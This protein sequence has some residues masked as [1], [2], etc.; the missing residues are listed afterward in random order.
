[1]VHADDLLCLEQLLLGLKHGT[2]GQGKRYAMTLMIFTGDVH[3]IMPIVKKA[4]PLGPEQAAKSFFFVEGG[5]N[6]CEEINLTINMR[7]AEGQAEFREFQRKVGVD[8]YPHIRFPHDHDRVHSRYIPVP[9]KFVRLNENQFIREIFNESILNGD[10]MALTKRVL[11]A[12]INSIVKR[13]NERIIA[14]LPADR[15]S[16]TYLS[17][18]V[19]DG[20]NLADPNNALFASD[21]LQSINSP[22][23]SNI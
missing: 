23:V 14:M 15:E 20:Y 21:N 5:A 18:N 8:F 13:L 16:R 12:P 19:P 3:Q 9:N 17:T 6:A 2:R 1:M 4:D 10:R 7:L 11:L 22:S